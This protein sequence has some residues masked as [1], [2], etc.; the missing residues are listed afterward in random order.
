MAGNPARSARREEPPIKP[1]GKGRA[2]AAPDPGPPRPAKLQRTGRQRASPP[3][4]EDLPLGAAVQSFAVH[5]NLSRRE[6]QVLNGAAHGRSNKEIASDLGISY[7]TVAQYWERI[8]CKTARDGQTRILGALFLH[9]A[10][11]RRIGEI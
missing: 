2:E 10:D 1:A 4:A 11:R 6:A 7:K 5:H 8:S 3:G 9:V